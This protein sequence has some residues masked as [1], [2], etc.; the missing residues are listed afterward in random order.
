MSDVEELTPA[1][2]EHAKRL[3]EEMHKRSNREEV[4]DLDD[5]SGYRQVDVYIGHL[6][7]LFAELQIANPYY[8]KIMAALKAQGCIEQL[9]RGG[10][11]A[12]SKWLLKFP[13]EEET[14]RQIL[15]R[16]RAPKGKTHQLEQRTHDL[17]RL[18]Q[19]LQDDIERLEMRL[20]VVERKLEAAK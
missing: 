11:S 2:F 20:Q 4:E 12:T 3:Y 1:L 6:T 13:P 7:R 9:R 5:P 18:S 15:E 8:T 10:G 14:F 17:M 19:S 16:K